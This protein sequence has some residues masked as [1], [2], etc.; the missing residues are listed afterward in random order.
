MTTQ[1]G[2]ATKVIPVSLH[3]IAF[4]GVTF[5]YT[6]SN[7]TLYAIIYN[8]YLKIIGSY[9]SGIETEERPVK[10]PQ[11]PLCKLP[12]FLLLYYNTER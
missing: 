2:C 10:H 3:R 8:N 6:C 5:V 9:F 11:A 7:L 12:V 1:D 4:V